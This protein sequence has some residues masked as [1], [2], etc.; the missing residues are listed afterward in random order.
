MG[1]K[2]AGKIKDLGGRV[3]ELSSVV[4]NQQ[5]QLDKHDNEMADLNKAIHDARFPA[6]TT[7]QGLPGGKVPFASLHFPHTW[8]EKDNDFM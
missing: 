5:K 4:G 3:D 1:D 8:Q 7:A 6:P 2:L